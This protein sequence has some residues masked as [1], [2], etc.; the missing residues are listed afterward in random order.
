ME[1]AKLIA[2]MLARLIASDRA[3]K[4]EAGH[5]GVGDW[6]QITLAEDPEDVCEGRI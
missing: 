4:G 3:F 1:P 2:P 5:L 6:Q